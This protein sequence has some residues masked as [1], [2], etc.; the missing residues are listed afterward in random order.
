MTNGLVPLIALAFLYSFIWVVPA[1]IYGARRR[2]NLPPYLALC[3]FSMF[4]ELVLIYFLLLLCQ[5]VSDSKVGLFV[6][7][8]FSA[9]VAGWFYAYVAKLRDAKSITRKNGKGFSEI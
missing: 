8:V 2:R 7:P 5:L 9:G 4:T 1:V 3:L 6:V